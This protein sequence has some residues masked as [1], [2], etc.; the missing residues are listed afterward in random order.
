MKWVS[1]LNQYTSHPLPPIFLSSSSL[2][3]TISLLLYP[4]VPYL[5]SIPFTLFSNAILFHSFH[6]S[7]PFIFLHCHHL[8]SLLA[9][10]YLTY[11]LSCTPMAFSTMASLPVCQCTCNACAI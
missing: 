4:P 3:S 2:L 5:F 10:F 1:A 6:H 11:T 7:L 9:R 8:P